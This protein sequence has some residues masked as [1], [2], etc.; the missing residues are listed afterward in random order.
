MRILSPVVSGAA[1]VV[2]VALAITIVVV[3][4]AVDCATSRDG[5]VR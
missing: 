1:L 5:G 3:G 2:L 4:A